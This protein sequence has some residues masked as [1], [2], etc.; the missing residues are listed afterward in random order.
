MVAIRHVFAL[1]LLAATAMSS[2]LVHAVEADSIRISVFNSTGDKAIPAFRVIAGVPAPGIADEYEK[3]TGKAV[4]NWQPHTVKVGKD[5]EYI[6]PLDKAYEEMALRVEA[7]GYVPQVYLWL[8]KAAGPQHL[9]FQLAADA[10]VKGR[11]LQPGGKPAAG[12]TVALAMPQRDAVWEEGR[13]R[14]SDKLLPEKP[15]DRWRVPIFVK[16]DAEGR[17][18]LPTEPEPAAVLIVHESGVR[19]LA[20]DEFQKSPEV[21]LQ[22]WG[23]I[24]GRVLWKDKPGAGEPLTLSVHRDEY[25]YPGM[26]A[27][28]A[29]TQS[30]AEGRFVFD[31]VLPGH[32][33]LSRPIQISPTDPSAGAWNFDGLIQHVQ[34]KPGD[35]TEVVLGGKGRKVTGKLT[36]RDSCEGVTFH[37]HPNAPHIG[38]GGDDAAWKAF[39][40]FQKS[41]MGPLFFRDKQPVNADGTFTI[42][43]MLPGHYQIFFAAPG[44]RAHLA[45]SKITVEPEVVG[46]DPAVLDVGAIPVKVDKP[47]AA[48]PAAAKPPVKTVT[49]RGKAVDDETGKPVA[50]LIVQAGKFDPADPTK[51]TWGFSEN[52]S[53]A[54][55]GSYS[56]TVRWAEGWTARILA[57]GYLPQPILTKAPPEDKD[58]IE[59]LV[60]LKRGRLIRGQ[61]FD[62]KD[63]PVKGMAVYAVGPTGV[64]VAAGKAWSS[65]GEEDPTPKPVLT[66]D[67]GR[68]E[69]AAGEA[70]KLAVSGSAIDTWPSEIAA[71]GDTIIRLPEPAKVEIQLDIEGAEKESQVFLQLL[72]SHMKGFEG[73]RLE[74]TL[75]IGNGGKLMLPALPPGKYQF[76]RSVSNNLGM[77]GV[78]TMLER[79][80][81]ELKP[82]E[83]KTINYV[84]AKGA[85]VRGQLTLPAEK[86]MGI[87]VRIN[88]EKA[89]KDPF[90]K[91][92]WTTTYASQTVNE[93]GSYLTERLAPGTY[94]LQAEAYVPLTPEQQFRTGLIVPPYSTSAKIE[95]PE[96]GELVVPELKLEKVR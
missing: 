49:I 93:D 63:K 8:K 83:T 88:A 31:R 44:E 86:L 69:I 89:E 23:R 32:V 19:E 13:L 45:S 92:E 90:D 52:R 35:P 36:G 55:D 34:V 77:I 5:G 85:R 9:T 43:N 62:H 4:V 40:E 75:P 70:K 78:G 39:G 18:E 42:E 79:Q 2:G 67:A 95:V 96:S 82:G 66:D 53:G 1:Q 41:A 25:G 58:E 20:Y 91:H 60:R 76:C 50:P 28:Y 57:D 47:A 72:V 37:F 65:W 54:T 74:R 87:V 80:F 73:V 46:K 51:V 26:V 21:T 17:F 61:V 16:S 64:N 12:A 30:D 29:K 71:E 3:R 6:W 81:L 59:V 14:G 10:G 94:V 7:D 68:F 84:R 56:T 48:A 11:V 33:Q 15:G 22:R 27:S 38:F 24:E